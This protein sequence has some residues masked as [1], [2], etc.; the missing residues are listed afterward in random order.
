VLSLFIFFA[1]QV[2]WS[3]WWLRRHERGPVEELWARITYAGSETAHV[4]TVS[5]R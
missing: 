5:Q 2:P 4:A 3:M 1:V